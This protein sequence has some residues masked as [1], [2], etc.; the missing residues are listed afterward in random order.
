MSDIINRKIKNIGLYLAAE[1]QNTTANRV[2]IANTPDRKIR[3]RI[4]YTKI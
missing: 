1:S 4:I 2:V 3:L